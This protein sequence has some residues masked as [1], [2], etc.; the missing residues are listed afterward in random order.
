VDGAVLRADLNY[1]T[2]GAGSA[3]LDRAV[4][5]AL[6]PSPDGLDIRERGSGG[7]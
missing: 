3:I 4:V 6:G 7:T 5:H 2:V 1:I